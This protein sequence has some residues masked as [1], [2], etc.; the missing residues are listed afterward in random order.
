MQAA[1][2]PQHPVPA[3]FQEIGSFWHPLELIRCSTRY[4]TID[5]D[6]QIIFYS[7]STSQK[8]VP[9]GHRS[10]CFSFSGPHV[11]NSPLQGIDFMA[12]VR[13][14][15]RSPFAISW[16]LSGFPYLRSPG[17]ARTPCRGALTVR[18]GLEALYKLYRMKDMVFTG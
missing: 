8:K 4:F 15:S 13:C 14:L 16:A 3:M 17:R 7:H 11:W 5:F 9:K 6:A 10:L 1:T 12:Q 18:R 2:K